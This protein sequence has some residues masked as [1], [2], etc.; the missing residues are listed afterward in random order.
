MIEFSEYLPLAGLTRRG[1]LGALGTLAPLLFLPGRAAGARHPALTLVRRSDWSGFRPNFGRLK[2]ALG[3]TRLTIHHEGNAANT[4]TDEE[5]LRYHLNGVLEAHLERRYGD[6]A[7]HFVVDYAGRIWEGRSLTCQGAHVAGE[8]H[9][10]L[11]VMLL[12]NFDEQSPSTDQIYTLTRLV[13]L[14]CRQYRIASSCVFGHC[15]LGSTTCPGRHLYNPHVLAFRG[16]VQQL[17]SDG[18]NHE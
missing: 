3:F 18:E 4:E 11:G 6:I 13:K 16:T 10:N 8:N 14:L 15:D 2:E 7:Y 17:E 1:F 12:G 9:A 5:L